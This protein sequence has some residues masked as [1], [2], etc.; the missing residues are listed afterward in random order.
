ME[1]SILITGIRASGKTT[2]AKEILSTYNHGTVGM[3]HYREL[4]STPMN[5]IEYQ[6]EVLC[7][8]DVYNLAQ[9]EYV[10]NIA[11]KIKTFIIVTT[12]LS[13]NEIPENILK[14]FEIINLQK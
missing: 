9:L 3:I 7:I 8:E 12:Q 4:I 14:S 5:L 10:A 11:K 6:Y 2:K 13:L 1:K